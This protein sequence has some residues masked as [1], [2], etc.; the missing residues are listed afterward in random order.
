MTGSRTKTAA[1]LILGWALCLVVAQPGLAQSRDERAVRAAYIF[2]LIKLVEWPGD[3]KEV[4][5]GLL[6][7]RETSEFL[8][9]MLDGKSADSRAIHVMLFPSDEELRK[10]NIVYVADEQRKVVRAILDK[11]ADRPILS[12][13]ESDF[14]AQDGG[15]IALIEFG[16][17]IQPQLNADAVQHAGIKISPRFV[18]LAKIVQPQ[19]QGASARKVLQRRD[20][21]YPPLALKMSLHGAVKL[22]LSIAAD[23]TVRSAECIGGHPVLAESAIK[24]VKSWKFEVAARE[25][26]ESV[27]VNF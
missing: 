22:K 14:F 26:T 16:E 1:A 4:V 23:G 21:E 7:D 2:N 17:Q 20:P 6:G 25:S 13:G 3:N 27:E 24:A 9:K 19:N 8:Q 11:I 12:V 18:A 5:I 15:M 10:C